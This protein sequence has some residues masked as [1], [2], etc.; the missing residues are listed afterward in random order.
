MDK[1]DKVVCNASCWCASGES[2]SLAGKAL[3]F[4]KTSSSGN[5]TSDSQLAQLNPVPQLIT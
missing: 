2:L 5:N 1:V 3:G 4:V